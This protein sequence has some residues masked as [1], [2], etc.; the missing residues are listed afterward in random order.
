MRVGLFT[1]DLA[2]ELP[3]SSTAL[4]YVTTLAPSVKPERVRSVL[5]A[6]GLPGNSALRTIGKL[7][8]G[9]KARVALAALGV[10]PNNVLLLDEPT[11]HLDVETVDVLVNALR[12]FEGSLLLVTHDRH[13]VEAVA[14]HIWHVRSGHVTA[15]EGVSPADFDPAHD[16][17]PAV[18]TQS[19]GAES[20]AERKKRQRERERAK[21]R[22]TAI[23]G[24]LEAA[25]AEIARIDDALFECAADYTK[26][27][28]L[29]TERRAAS[30]Q[31]DALYAEWET[32]ETLLADAVD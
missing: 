22:L 25:E 9:E 7:S 11:N 12:A 15:K 19:E 24:E 16:P 5:G 28:A 31:V 32:L 30:T 10:V 8:G 21:R 6:L 23:E 18:T 4:E 17:R 1:Q 14:T 29:D 20:Y 13:L 26:A 2:A 27:S 3:A